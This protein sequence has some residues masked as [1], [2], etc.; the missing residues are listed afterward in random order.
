M[1]TDSETKNNTDENGERTIEEALLLALHEQAMDEILKP[2]YEHL[3]DINKNDNLY[4]KIYKFTVDFYAEGFIK[5][6]ELMEKIESDKLI[7][8]EN[9]K[10]SN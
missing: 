6:M 1:K 3:W 5:G 4:N 2:D 7:G 9:L 10:I 8:K